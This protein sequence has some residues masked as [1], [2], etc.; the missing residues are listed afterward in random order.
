MKFSD[1]KIE[2]SVGKVRLTEA[3]VLVL[4]V[5]DM[6]AVEYWE[7]RLKALK[8]SY[9]IAFRKEG[10]KVLYSIFADLRKKGSPFR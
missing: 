5:T 1:L 8:Q 4:D 7:E 10:E 3:N 9:V 6:E 2:Y